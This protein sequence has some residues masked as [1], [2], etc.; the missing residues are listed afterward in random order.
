MGQK[1]GEN[2]DSLDDTI[3]FQVNEETKSIEQNIIREKNEVVDFTSPV[4]VLDENIVDN[5]NGKTR[6]EKQKIKKE[7]PK[8]EKKL[9]FKPFS[10]LIGF[11]SGLS[12]LKKTISILSFILIILI[13]IIAIKFLGKTDKK[14]ETN[15]PDVIIKKDNYR[16]ENGKLIILGKDDKEL[17]SYK[18]KNK[19]DKKCYVAFQSTEDDFTGDLYVDQEG[20]KLD[21]RSKVVSDNYVFVV[22][23]KKGSN[24]DIILYSV[25]SNTNI[26]EYSLVKQSS[27][28]SNYVVL[29]DKDG[30]YG[31]L[32]L[33]SDE[34]KTIINFVYNYAGLINNDMA[35]K[36]VVLSKNGKYY[37]SD[38]TENILSSGLSNKIVEY[39]D[40]YLVTKDNDGKYEIFNYEG[41]NLLNASY[42]FIKLS[43]NFY[44][45]VS[46][47]GLFVFDKEKNK[48]NELPIA[49]SSTTYNKTYVFDANNQMIS[50][51]VAFEI[52]SSE[53]YITVT[54]GKAVDTLSVKETL[55]NKE[56]QYINY[57]NGILYFYGDDA[58]TNLLGKYT[59]KNRNNP[60]SL[61]LCNVATST[62]FSNN[63]MTSNV[64]KGIV[65]I[66]NNRFVFVKDSLSTGGIYLYDLKDNKR[67]GPYNDIEAY[68]LV[69]DKETLKNI[70]GAFVIAKNKNNQFGLLRINSESVDILL[71][72]EYSEIEKEGEYFLVKKSNGSYSLINQSGNQITKDISS[73]ILSYSENYL[74]TKSGSGYVIYNYEGNKLDE[75]SYAD[76]TLQ[77]N[78]YIGVKD[79]NLGIYKYTNP[80][81][82][83]LSVNI[84]I[85]Y[86]ENWKNSN[87]YKVTSS[88]LGYII[89][90]ADGE[91]NKEYT[92]DEN[93]T[94]K[95]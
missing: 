53:D 1:S 87:Y 89:N 81:V 77:S 3:V 85:K 64:A 9:K 82:N 60:G 4:K 15:T 31:V 68:D 76:I 17:G 44:A 55:T 67:L 36:Y 59:C 12:K 79:N 54:R 33:S 56:H 95:E 18:C 58:K 74:L 47:N 13:V 57:F 21:L 16:Y 28:N 51:D 41:N 34:P 50:N 66:I 80:G 27:I 20:K 93:G 73:K 61:D 69:S 70:N 8:K 32:D 10:K 62:S 65:A 78:Y 29:K 30:K 86:P 92:F 49:L 35:N 6:A 72:F 38:F 7:K 25:K 40:I 94:L 84:P 2:I 42:L 39:N 91:N 45:V 63:D 52:S 11:W 46:S 75:S 22:D 71:N 14:E 88:T 90:I 83:I 26:G 5:T 24:D 43:D 19:D 37:L 48:Y 23:N